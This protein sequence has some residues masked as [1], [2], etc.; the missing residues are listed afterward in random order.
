MR[1]KY[2]ILKRK[3]PKRETK[4]K[5][6]CLSGATSLFLCIF[7]I[8]T[9]IPHISLADHNDLEDSLQ[10]AYDLA[11]MTESDFF[12]ADYQYFS[13]KIKAAADNLELAIK[14]VREG[15]FKDLIKHIDEALN[16]IKICLKSNPPDQDFYYLELLIKNIKKEALSRLR[17]QGLGP[18]LT[19]A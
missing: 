2:Y 10:S 19:P 1:N 16:Q 6:L 7:L 4:R 9:F 3:K 17:N 8:F 5:W 13:Y 12:V 14:E 15:L 18:A 11:R